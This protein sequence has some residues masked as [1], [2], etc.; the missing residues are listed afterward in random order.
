MHVVTISSSLIYDS[1]SIYLYN[2][3]DFTREVRNDVKVKGGV[4]NGW[5]SNQKYVKKVCIMKR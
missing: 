2:S 1:H 3:K 4:Q 5:K